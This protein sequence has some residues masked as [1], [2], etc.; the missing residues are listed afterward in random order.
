MK[1]K[2]RM[3]EEELK[4]KEEALQ[5]KET[6]LITKEADLKAKEEALQKRE[7][8]LKGL[9]ATMTASYEK[10]LA[11]QKQDYEARLKEREE[12]IKQLLEGSNPNNKE[13]SAIDE[14]NKKRMAQRI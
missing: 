11:E 13:P 8:D 2:T 9:T 12:V 10:K 6:E 14:L 5:K 7:E 3:N 1:G 4:A